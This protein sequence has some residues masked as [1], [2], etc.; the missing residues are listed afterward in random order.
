MSLNAYLQLNLTSDAESAKMLFAKASGEAQRKTL[1][2]TPPYSADGTPAYLTPA[3]S[4]WFNAQIQPVR[5]SA[6]HE[7]L[8]L[9]NSMPVGRSGNRAKLFEHERDKLET[10]AAQKIVEERR[11]FQHSSGI[12][13]VHRGLRVESA[14]YEAMVQEYGEALKWRPRLYW[15]V[16]IFMIFVL[17]GLINFES[18]LKIPGFTPALSVGSF[19]GVSTAFAVSAHFVGVIFK[20]WKDRLG[21]SVSRTEKMKTRMLLGGATVLFVLAFGFVIYARWALLGDIILRRSQTTGEEIGTEEVVR[22]AG[23]LI[24]N[25]IVYVMGVIWA[26]VRHDAIPGFSELRNR[27]EDLQARES[28]LLDS[29]L[30]SRNRRHMS[31]AQDEKEKLRR[32]IQAQSMQVAEYQSGRGRFD[33]LREQDGRVI[34]L[35]DEYRAMLLEK[36]ADGR[37]LSFVFDNAGKV[38]VETEETITADQYSA[39]PLELKYI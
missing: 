29:Q 12:N 23:T 15:A 22:F 14:R 37:S 24:G 10:E 21:G 2:L 19:I 30:A 5:R 25:L 7:I 9:F 33:Q 16:L 13:D 4:S 28:E 38:A 3:M 18:F 27:V 1:P 31:K 17:E 20:Q 39:A 8:S 26:Y 11:L 34:A 35:L 6:L 32:A 36:V